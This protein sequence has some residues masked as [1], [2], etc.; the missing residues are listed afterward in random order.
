LDG[1]A[2]KRRDIQVLQSITRNRVQRDFEPEVTHE[3][4]GI[5]SVMPS[6]ERERKSSGLCPFTIR[7]DIKKQSNPPVKAALRGRWS[8]RGSPLRLV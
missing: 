5:E 3:G 2:V 8:S 4:V 7:R 6:T 1:R